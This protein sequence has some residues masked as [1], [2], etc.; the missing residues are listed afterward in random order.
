MDIARYAFRL[1]IN[2]ELAGV[3]DHYQLL[4]Y[5]RRDG[6]DEIEII[7]PKHKRK[8]LSRTHYPGLKLADILVGG[9]I[10]IYSRQYRVADFEDDFTRK[11]LGKSKQP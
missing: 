3:L 1:E 10:T 9:K 7:D 4:Y 8:F 2:N 6:K 5:T 11:E